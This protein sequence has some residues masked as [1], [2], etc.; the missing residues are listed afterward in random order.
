MESKRETSNHLLTLCKKQELQLHAKFVNKKA[1]II[2]KGI[3][4][5]N[6]SEF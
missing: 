5:D 6:G 2:V 4:N 1:K 3:T